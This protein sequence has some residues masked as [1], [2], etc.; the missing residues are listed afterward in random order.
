MLAAE[1]AVGAIVPATGLAAAAVESTNG[2]VVL[3]SDGTAAAR[4]DEAVAFPN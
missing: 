1:A 2:F 3:V 4:F